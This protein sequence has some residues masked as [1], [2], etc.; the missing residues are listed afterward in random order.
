MTLRN[1]LTLGLQTKIIHSY[2][3]I[4]KFRKFSENN[5]QPLDNFEKFSKN[6]SQPLDKFDKFSEN[7]STLISLRIL[8]KITHA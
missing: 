7:N 5:S 6:N 8:A 1:A 4:N 3:K 2:K